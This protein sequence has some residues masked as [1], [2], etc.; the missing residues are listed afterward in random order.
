MVEHL[1]SDRQEAESSSN[2]KGSE[3]DIVLKD[4]P[5]MICLY[6][7]RPTFHN[8]R[9]VYSDFESI[10]R[11]KTFIRSDPHDLIIYGDNLIDMSK[12]VLY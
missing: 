1:T 12:G 5:P 3:Q 7:S 9:V 10:N 4:L 6:Q 8:I 2:R 11:F